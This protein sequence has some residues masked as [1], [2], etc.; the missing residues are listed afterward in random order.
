[1]KRRRVSAESFDG[2]MASSQRHHPVSPLTRPAKTKTK[3][4][5]TKKKESSSSDESEGEDEDT[6]SSDETDLRVKLDGSFN[7]TT[8]Y[9]IRYIEKVLHVS[10]DLFIKKFKRSSCKKRKFT[11]FLL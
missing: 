8:T 10:L 9:S 5:L 6:G 7:N 3:H 2:G 1:M 4:Q 11:N